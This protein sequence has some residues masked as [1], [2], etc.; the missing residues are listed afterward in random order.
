MQF[1]SGGANSPLRGPGL[2]V[3]ASSSCWEPGEAVI[4]REEVCP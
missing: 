3:G 1:F 4:N 2:P